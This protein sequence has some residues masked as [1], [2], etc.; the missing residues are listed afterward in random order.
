MLVD[1][2]W[3]KENYDKYNKLCWGGRLP[4]WL[5]FEVNQS[6]N[7][8]GLA[9]YSYN[10]STMKVTP[11]KITLSNYYDSS[12]SVKLNTLI[13]EMI[14]IADYTFNPQ[15]FLNRTRN[16]RR[17]YDAHGPIFFQPEAERLKQFGFDVHK[18]VTEEEQA[19]SQLSDYQ[20][21]L[22]DRRIR[23]GISVFMFEYK[24]GCKGRKGDTYK[25]GF[26]RTGRSNYKSY[27]EELER[28]VGTGNLLWVDEYVATDNAIND[29]PISRG[30]QWYL[31]N[32][33]QKRID[34]YHLKFKR[35][36]AGEHDVQEHGNDDEATNSTKALIVKF[37]PAIIS[38][39]QR[40]IESHFTG[41][42][43]NEPIEDTYPINFKNGQQK[44]EVHINDNDDNYVSGNKLFFSV[45]PREVEIAMHKENP[46]EYLKDKIRETLNVALM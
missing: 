1:V 36:I 13:H 29:L 43:G 28:L 4:N 42:F 46:G 38:S 27:Y 7:Y 24:D 8:W 18:N 6:K 3:L 25:F 15:H 12:E 40:H 2:R 35:T 31:T 45:S 11:T 10:L 16:K 30:L 19:V 14:H 26:A 44:I 9:S 23:E 17:K 20:Q 21:G 41:L 32:D 37:K 5:T 22:L 34:K 39:I 33:L